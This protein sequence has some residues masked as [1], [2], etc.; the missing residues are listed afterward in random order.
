MR[1]AFTC[2]YIYLF[3]IVSL[4]LLGLLGKMLLQWLLVY[5]LLSN[6]VQIL[7]SPTVCLYMFPHC[8]VPAKLCF[9]G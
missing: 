6:N 2:L 8:S 4:A 7:Q 5:V 9:K 3:H 1:K